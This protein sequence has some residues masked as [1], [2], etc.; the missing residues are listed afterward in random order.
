MPTAR[1][2]S[3]AEVD[4]LL[5]RG[6]I[7]VVDAGERV[8]EHLLA[9]SLGLADSA[10]LSVNRKA[11]KERS[12]KHSQKGRQRL[13]VMVDGL[14]A[15][16]AA[17]LKRCQW[18]GYEVS[19]EGTTL[20]QTV[21]GA[22]VWLKSKEHTDGYPTVLLTSSAKTLIRRCAACPPKIVDGVE[23]VCGVMWRMDKAHG[24][25]PRKRVA[26]GAWSGDHLSGSLQQQVRQGKRRSNSAFPAELEAQITAET[27]KG[28][29]P[30]RIWNDLVDVK[31]RSLPEAV[32]ARMTGRE[33][34][35]AAMGF[36]LKKVQKFVSRLREG[37]GNGFYI[38]SVGQLKVSCMHVGNA[39][40]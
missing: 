20:P 10:S 19:G 32:R 1:R 4:D 39:Y 26:A 22:A 14:G 13:H 6:V 33:K 15:G 28:L 17:Q 16:G 2:G 37:A 36:T 35:A 8:K 3:L 21:K 18:V 7:D 27:R 38:E 5:Q 24:W 23:R 9:V 31:Y 12:K 29:T 30:K 40:Y 11:T 34:V 25:S